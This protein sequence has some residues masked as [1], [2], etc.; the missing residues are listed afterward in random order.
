V[1]PLCCPHQQSQPAYPSSGLVDTFTSKTTQVLTTEIKSDDAEGI[2][3][4]VQRP[5]GKRIKF[6]PDWPRTEGATCT[7]CH[8]K[9]HTEKQCQLKSRKRSN[10]STLSTNDADIEE[11]E[12]SAFAVDNPVGGNGDDDTDGEESDASVDETVNSV[13]TGDLYSGDI[14]QCVLDSAAT[15]HITPHKQLLINMHDV[16]HVRLTT[17]LR[18]NSGVITRAGTLHLNKNWKLNDVAYVSNAGLTLISEGKLCESNFIILKNKEYALVYPPGTTYNMSRKPILQCARKHRLWM[19]TIP[20][21]SGDERVSPERTQPTIQ[22]RND[23]STK[24]PTHGLANV[25]ERKGVI[26]KKNQ[27]QSVITTRS[28]TK[29]S[30]SSASTNTKPAPVQANAAIESKKSKRKRNHQ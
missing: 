14:N 20:N 24:L 7:F 21:K 28:S 16:P 12:W 5:N 11:G 29:Q 19:H 10:K 27:F 18:K 25:N 30:V 1:S 22:L 13:I 17:A 4:F 3:S 9:N 8:K 6:H 15:R 2:H 26:P 23:D